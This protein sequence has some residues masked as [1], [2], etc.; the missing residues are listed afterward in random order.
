MPDNEGGDVRRITEPVEIRT[1][2]D[3]G[4]IAV[5]GSAYDAELIRSGYDATVQ[6]DTSPQGRRITA[7]PPPETPA[8]QAAPATAQSAPDTS[9]AA[10]NE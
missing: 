5:K 8:V 3:A 10:P 9:P 4:P 7:S 1:T 6:V 2:T